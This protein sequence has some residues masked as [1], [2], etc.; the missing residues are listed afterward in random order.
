M[1]FFLSLTT[2]LLAAVGISTLTSQ[3]PTRADSAAA[4]E[5]PAADSDKIETGAVE[6][7]NEMGTY[8][9]SLKS[10]QIQSEATSEIVMPD[11]Q[12]VQLAQNTNLLARVPDRLMADIRGDQGA[13]LYMF[14]GKSFAFLARDENF[15]AVVPAPPTLKQL[16]NILEDKYDVE[17]PLVDLF[18]W[19]QADTTPP[20]ITSATDIGPGEVGGITCEHYAFRQEGL[21]WQV[22]IQQGDYPLPRKLVLTTTT[23][24]ARPQHTSVLNWNLAPSYNEDSF[25][26]DPPQGAHKIEF[27]SASGEGNK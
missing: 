7:L 14:D 23:D 26:F 17:L 12:K 25:K 20:K 16:A 6:A 19:G 21:D 8:L 9:R 15:Y 1:K 5:T 27:A 18:L 10:F 22:W 3:R 4:Q 2:A 11:G 13:K 24:E